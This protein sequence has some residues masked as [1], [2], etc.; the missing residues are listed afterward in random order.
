[1]TRFSL[2]LVIS[3]S[4]EEFEAAVREDQ[5]AKGQR[6]DVSAADRE[7]GSLRIDY[8]GLDRGGMYPASA[9]HPSTGPGMKF[10]AEFDKKLPLYVDAMLVS[11]IAGVAYV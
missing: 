8:S 11:A 9:Q 4:D 7:L 1:M 2:D 10:F 6:A 5:R 3:L